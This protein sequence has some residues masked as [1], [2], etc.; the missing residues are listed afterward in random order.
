MIA[1][2]GL[3]RLQWPTLPQHHVFGNRGLRNTDAELEQLTMDLGRS[4]ERV[5]ET[6][7]PNEFTRLFVDPRPA[8]AKVGFTPP[9]HSDGYTGKTTNAKLTFYSDHSVGADQIFLRDL[10]CPTGRIAF[11]AKGLPTMFRLLS[12]C[13]VMALCFL[14]NGSASAAGGGRTHVY[15][16]RG[17][18][19]VSVGL[20]ALARKLARLD[21]AAS[22]HS[23]GDG[24]SVAAEATRDYKSGRIRS[25]VLI[26][27][28]LGAGAVLSAARTL[29]EAGVP[30]A[31]L[32]ALDPV[33]SATV[34][35]NVRR[36]VNFYVSGSGVPVGAEP[37]FHGVLKN[38]DVSGDP[39]MSHMAVQATDK[40]HSRMIGY[41]RAL[42]ADRRA[43]AAN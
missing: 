35:P 29:N 21:I 34:A 16:L 15:L 14:G 41:V 19:N 30:V 33:S 4:P 10:R 28:S 8:T 37:G 5:F 11:P 7:P 23:H 12:C 25:I 38:V 18:A 42:A 43:T 22:V 17:I 27:H 2:E 3:P 39:G 32:I 26:G 1:M 20:D 6:D 9:T 40:M 31:L 36:A 24:A 13:L